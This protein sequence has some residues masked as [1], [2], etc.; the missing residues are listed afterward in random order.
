MAVEQKTKTIYYEELGLTQDHLL[1]FLDA[2]FSIAITLLV[3]EISLDVPL[4]GTDAEIF[5][6]LIAA[7]PAAVSYIISFFVIASYWMYAHRMFHY[8]RKIDRKFVSLTLVFLFFIA[9][10]PFPTL[11][12]G[13][14]IGRFPAVVFYC[15][16]ISA[17]SFI[18]Y[19]MW[20]YA[21]D[22]RLVDDNVDAHFKAYKS[23]RM[24]STASV[25]LTSVP[26]AF[27]NPLAAQIWWVLVPVASRAIMYWYNVKIRE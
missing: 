25:F 6:G 7:V 27:I 24:L 17:S 12:L 19:L 11:V 23:A 5:A 1:A 8:I 10:M 16:A 4:D 3:L 20:K 15:A 18:M 13:Q 26:I 21:C 9:F 22:A 2:I 14:H